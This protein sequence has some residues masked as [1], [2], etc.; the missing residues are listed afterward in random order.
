MELSSKQQ[1]AQ[2]LLKDEGIMALLNEYMLE[3]EEHLNPQ[4]IAQMSDEHIGQLTR[5]DITADQKIRS[6]FSR[7]KNLAKPP[8]DKKSAARS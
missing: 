2:R 3:V 6:R 7:I 1:A 8:G 5:A 4:L